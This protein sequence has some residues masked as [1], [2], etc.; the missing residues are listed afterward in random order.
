MAHTNTVVFRVSATVVL[1]NCPVDVAIFSICL[2]TLLR[3]RHCLATD[4][5]S[6]YEYSSSLSSFMNKSQIRCQ[7]SSCQIFVGKSALWPDLWNLRLVQPY[8]I[9]PPR[10]MVGVKRH[11]EASWLLVHW[12]G[13]MGIYKKQSYQYYFEQP[14]A[15]W[16]T[17][18]GVCQVISSVKGCA[19]RQDRQWCMCVTRLMTWIGRM[20][21]VWQCYT[22][23]SAVAVRMFW[24]SLFTPAAMSTS[25]TVTDG[26]FIYIVMHKCQTNRIQVWNK[27]S[28]C[29]L[30]E[31]KLCFM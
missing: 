11:F 2:F 28:W 5:I 16:I 3:F 20:K 9:P 15:F 19:R 30:E 31:H 23:E 17:N 18:V 13:G 12:H 4:E 1:R 6:H 14:F 8:K 29:V 21:M 24:S 26:S 10:K 25:P 22:T 27:I 7:P